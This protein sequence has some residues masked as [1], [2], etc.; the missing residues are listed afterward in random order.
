MKPTHADFLA[1]LGKIEKLSP[2]PM[3]L[4]KAMR[5]LKDANANADELVGVIRSDPAMAAD[6][7]RLANSAR[8]AS[9]T[10]VS[11][12]DEAVARLGFAEVYRL[13]GLSLAQTVLRSP[14][15]CSGLEGPGFWDMSVS[16]AVLMESLAQWVVLDSQEAY[17]AGL[18]HGIGRL[19]IGQTLR[20]LACAAH[21]D[22]SVPTAQWERETVGLDHA[23][24]GAL[25]M[26]RWGFGDELC[27]AIAQQLSLELIPEPPILCCALHDC[28]SLL[29]A[30]DGALTPAP[31]FP[32]PPE[33]LPHVHL[34]PEHVPEL[35]DNAWARFQAVKHALGLGSRVALPAEAQ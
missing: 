29:S 28:V 4:A 12:L 16:C 20:D 18:L 19:A 31:L 21:P 13:L 9:G 1:A 22:G 10:R 15:D 2:A 24:A 30:A 11:A 32:M 3:V 7:L 25:L 6:L 17:T 34:E 27:Q 8:A 23:A 33:G 26:R 35:I 5:L 14:K